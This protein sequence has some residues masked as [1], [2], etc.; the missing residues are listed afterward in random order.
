MTRSALTSLLRARQI[1]RSLY[2]RPTFALGVIGA[3][4]LGIGANGA[5]FTVL[6]AV[7]LAKI[8]AVQ[9]QELARVYS[10]GD[11]NQPFGPMSFATFHALARDTTMTR[12]WSASAVGVAPV[13]RSGAVASVPAL[14]VSGSFFHVLGLRPAIGR[15][16]YDED[17]VRGTTAVVLSYRTWRTEYG[18][19]TGVT[20]RSIIIGRHSYGI[21]GV[22]PA[23]FDGTELLQAPEIYLPLS[24]LRD[25]PG[26]EEMLD[27]RDARWFRIIARL[28]P[29]VALSQLQLAAQRTIDAIAQAYPE[30]DA[31]QRVTVCSG[32]WLLSPN[33]EARY[34]VWLV[35][36]VLG[37]I[38]FLIHGIAICNA[39]NLLIARGLQRRREIT[40][41]LALGAS[42]G[43]LLSDTTMET[44][45]LALAGCG[46]GVGVM[47]LAFPLAHR[48][49]FLENVALT[50][51]VRVIGAMIALAL[52]T[53]AVCS[54]LP[55]RYG[56]SLALRAT[57]GDRG[58][59]E[60]RG[61]NLRFAL[62]GGQAGLSFLL[63]AGVALLSASLGAIQQ[64]DPGFDLDHLVIADLNLTAASHADRATRLV[65]Y[66]DLLRR[67]RATPGIV[68]ASSGGDALFHGAPMEDPVVASDATVEQSGPIMIAGEIVGPEYFRAT[69][70]RVLAGREFSSVDGPGAPIS[71]VV[72]DAFV[73]R[74]WPG[75]QAVGKRVHFR[76]STR[77]FQ[78]IGVVANTV[79]ESFTTRPM[80]R[81]FLP[82]R[83][84]TYFQFGLYVRTAGSPVAMTATVQQAIRDVDPSEGTAQVSTLAAVRERYL[85]PTTRILACLRGTA[86]VALALTITGMIAVT[87][88][89]VTERLRETAVR[90]ALGASERQ[91]VASLASKVAGASL[92]GLLA[93]L[94]IVLVATRS[95]HDRLYGTPLETAQ[96]IGAV[97]VLLLITIVCAVLVPIMLSR[98][99]S[100][101]SVL[102]QGA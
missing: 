17:D 90:R 95:T 44:A 99:E 13:Q 19:D 80:P 33:V 21:V 91:V 27:A 101:V 77:D 68:D 66:D 71:L 59:A 100:I 62:V 89:V 39:A 26:S 34:P 88:Q 96:A 10:S 83:A 11:P 18:G 25:I 2:R 53:A 46:V 97:F 12:G 50:P 98:R 55:L 86:L 85:E 31:G 58:N 87:L 102:N 92:I 64:G 73:R 15:L 38:A 14:F 67:L 82:F 36:Q 20:G 75:Q 72:N 76:G 6:Q 48:V 7:L 32:E 51:D 78:I 9:P 37:L 42:S 43:S 1:T 65:L 63:L 56:R 16:V 24:A 22:A 35:I 60:S 30:T 61:G 45:L 40:I 47:L 93:A 28:R 5:V 74:F 84:T 8:P 23:G 94:P 54:W 79:Y 57:L 4:A 69:G 29:G 81:Y 41:R 52:V 49:S 3:L 70:V